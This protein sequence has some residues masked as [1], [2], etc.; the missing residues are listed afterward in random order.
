MSEFEKTMLLNHDVEKVEI[1]NRERA[2]ITIKKDK[3]GLDRYKAVSHKPFGNGLNPGPHYYM[4]IG[5]VVGN[6]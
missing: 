1:V 5:D 3:L 6:S 4:P 2:E